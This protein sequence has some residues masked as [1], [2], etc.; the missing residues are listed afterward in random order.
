MY[1]D[2][3]CRDLYVEELGFSFSLSVVNMPYTLLSVDKRCQENGKDFVWP[4]SRKMLPYFICKDGSAVVMRV[5]YN[6]PSR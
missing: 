1:A 6:I 4:G 3:A 5:D 2:D